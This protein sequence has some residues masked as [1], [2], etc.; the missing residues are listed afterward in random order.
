MKGHAYSVSSRL[1][2][3]TLRVELHEAVLKVDLGREFLLELPRL[4]GARRAHVDFRHLITALLRKPGAF[5]HYRHREA[6][7]PS[8]VFRA[9][10]DRLV[11][12]HGERLG[13]IAYLQVLQLAAEETV[14]AVEPVLR[15]PLALAGQWRAFPVRAQ[16]VAVAGESHRPGGVDAQLGRLRHAAGKR[17][18]PGRLSVWKC[19]GGSSA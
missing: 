1:I 6:L 9:A 4:R 14:A 18:G 15:A 2:G 19:C 5:R 7:Y 3:H 10:Q 12:G 17:G 13:V 8:P 16:L 11:A